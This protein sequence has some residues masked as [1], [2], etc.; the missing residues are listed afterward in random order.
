MNLRR[1]RGNPQDGHVKQ[2]YIVAAVIAAFCA[3]SV[4]TAGTG[5]HTF[6]SATDQGD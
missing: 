2:R 1:V 5:W 3:G 6:A 4:A